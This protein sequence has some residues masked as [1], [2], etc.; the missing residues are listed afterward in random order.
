MKYINKWLLLASLVAG[1][2]FTYW[3]SIFITRVYYFDKSPVA[4]CYQE[5]GNI[6]DP[7]DCVF[8]Q[9]E[10]NGTPFEYITTTYE[11]TSDAESGTFVT[12]SKK[13]NYMLV[14]ANVLLVSAAVY[15]VLLAISGVHTRLSKRS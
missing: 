12:V 11:Y 14:A 5:D 8:V 3:S 6:V 4:V 10:T 1:S 15:I 13:T 9:K 7:S 2:L